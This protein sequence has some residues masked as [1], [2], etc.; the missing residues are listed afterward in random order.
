VLRQL[1][2]DRRVATHYDKRAAHYLAMLTL[3]ALLLWL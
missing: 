3:V 1:K 2:Q